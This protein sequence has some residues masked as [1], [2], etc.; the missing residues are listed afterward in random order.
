[1]DL[2]IFGYG[3]LVWRPDFPFAERVGA[4]V[5]GYARRFWQGS[6]DHRGTPDAPGRVVTLVPSDGQVLGV[7]YRLHP[8]DAP[9]ILARLE[10]REKEGYQTET[11]GLRLLDGRHVQGLVYL[12]TATNASYLGPASVEEMAAHI[13]QCA[14][15]SGPNSEYLLELH[16]ALVQMGEPDPHVAE[17][18]MAMT[19]TNP[20]R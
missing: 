12:A 18:V 16:A 3:S 19:S 7:A 4:H 1:M 20:S 11:L 10:H 14:G 2:W 9:H 6:P 17:L 13:G 8:S 5:E 15:P